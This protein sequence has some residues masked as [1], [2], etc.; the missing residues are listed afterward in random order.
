MKKTNLSLA[1]AGVAM[2]FLAAAPAEA[3][4]SCQQPECIRAREIRDR[5]NAIT[6]CNADNAEEV[7]RLSREAATALTACEARSAACAT[8]YRTA[9][10]IIRNGCDPAAIARE[11][12][13][14]EA[15]CTAR[16]HGTWC[17]AGDS[18][19]ECQCASDSAGRSCRR[20]RDRSTTA[21]WCAPV[22]GYQI[23]D[24]CLPRRI[25]PPPPPEPPVPPPPPPDARC[26]VGIDADGDGVPDLSSTCIPDDNCRI[27]YNPDQSD[28]DTDG[29]GDACDDDDDLEGLRREINARFQNLCVAVTDQTPVCVLIRQLRGGHEPRVSLDEIWSELRRL[30]A[31]DVEINRRLD[32]VERILHD[33]G[34]MIVD[35]GRR[36][37][38]FMDRVE[39]L[40]RGRDYRL[41]TEE[42]V[43]G[44]EVGEQAEGTMIREDR[45]VC[46]ETCVDTD[47]EFNSESGRCEARPMLPGEFDLSVGPA[48]SFYDEF[49]LG[50][51]L[52]ATWWL[53]ERFGWSL[54]GF[55]G[56]T[57]VRQPVLD[58]AVATG[59]SFRL[60]L[61]REF[62]LDLGLGAFGRNGT[63]LRDGTVGVFTGF[64]GYVDLAAIVGNRRSDVRVRIFGRLLLG[65][66]DSDQ[67]DPHFA[68]GVMGG[69]QLTF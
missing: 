59:P 64:G 54:W 41:A 52:D 47:A 35:L 37:G 15:R 50:V 55:A 14:C 69:L 25:P 39:C 43:A 61:E 57:V 60:V 68:P 3:Q 22:R 45:V 28:V 53:Q 42:R 13:F 58:I 11:P 1:L 4:D 36:I 48:V 12:S 51:E 56:L 63:S 46:L 9:V 29:E 18:R 38:L 24:R 67:T 2:A 6:E 17:A 8:A 33:H 20:E 32:E 5:M 30:A 40:R 26:N 49:T 27:R 65:F 34:D 44:H 16:G 23:L 62:S 7:I 10:E 19:A 66:A 31:E 21:H